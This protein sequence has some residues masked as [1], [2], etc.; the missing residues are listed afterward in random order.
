MMRFRLA[1]TRPKLYVGRQAEWGTTWFEFP[2]IL[3]VWIRRWLLES[4][5]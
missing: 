4:S 3:G 1:I 2:Q 5:F